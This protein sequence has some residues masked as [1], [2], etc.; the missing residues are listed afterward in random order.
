MAGIDDLI[1]QGP[2]LRDFSRLGQVFGAYREGVNSDSTGL[3]AAV[4][5]WILLRNGSCAAG[6]APHWRVVS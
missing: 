5:L 6:L 2:G 1:A 3:R 4:P